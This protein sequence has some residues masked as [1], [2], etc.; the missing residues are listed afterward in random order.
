M[1]STLM[2]IEG[3]FLLLASIKAQITVKGIRTKKTVETLM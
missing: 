1:G 3:L 2:P